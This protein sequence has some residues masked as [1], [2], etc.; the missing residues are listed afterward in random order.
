MFKRLRLIF[1]LLCA[2]DTPAHAGGAPVPAVDRAT[3]DTLAAKQELYELVVRYSRFVDRKDFAA[4]AHLYHPDAIHD[5]GGMFK[6]NGRDFADWLTRT[7]GTIETQHFI[8][9]AL[10]SV[11]GD[12]AEGEIYT[13]NYHVLPGGKRFYVAGGRYIDRYVKYEGHW[14]FAARTRVVDWS[15]ERA[16]TAGDTAARL[17]HG[18]PG[19]EDPS[20]RLLGPDFGKLP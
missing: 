4:L 13:V 16:L 20:Y 15:E 1:C 14:L 9:N 3:I 10:F 11:H 18:R 17:L 7:M 5:H 12:K 2:V 6:G 8:G 19:A